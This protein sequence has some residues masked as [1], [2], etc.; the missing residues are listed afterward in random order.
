MPTRGRREWA[1]SAL[2]CFLR[3]SYP[4]KELV[5]ID[6]LA[7]PSFKSPG[8]GIEYW[9]SQSR[10]IGWKRNE[11]CRMATGEIIMHWD[12]DDWS[13]SDRMA[14]QVAFLEASGKQVTGYSTL[15]FHE[16]NT[17]KWGRYL[18]DRHYSLGTSLCYFKS[19]WERH[20]FNEAV[21]VGEDNQFVSDAVNEGAFISQ[22]GRG[23]MVARVHTD[24]TT[25][26]DMGNFTG[27]VT[28][29]DIPVGFTA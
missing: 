5:I 16:G 3:Q 25:P 13:N 8:L 17:G 18:G 20:P 4:L 29:A 27:T 1:Q 22:E 26:K 9:L 7:D 2:D 6:D 11:A 14:E 15:L 24:N 23:M 12:S 19:W 28:P 10:N 21:T